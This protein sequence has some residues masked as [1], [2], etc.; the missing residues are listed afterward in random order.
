LAQALFGLKQA[1]S[2][3]F[4]LHCLNS[5]DDVY[6][7]INSMK[8]A[9]R[10]VVACIASL[11]FADV[12]AAPTA[13]VVTPPSKVAS[14]A[15]AT[16]TKG[17]PKVIRL[18]DAD[19]GAVA[20]GKAVFIPVANSCN[21][22]TP[23][24]EMNADGKGRFTITGA[25]GA[26]KLCYQA[27]GETD[28]VEQVPVS[29][30]IVLTLVQATT[31]EPDHVTQMEP[32]SITVNVKTDI[33]FPDAELGDHAY[34]VNAATG[35]CQSQVPTTMVG[36]KHN[37]FRITSTGTYTLCYRVPGAAE[38]VAQTSVSLKVIPQ[39]VLESMVNQWVRK[40]GT[41]DCNAL[42][43]ISHCGFFNKKGDCETKFF[44]D[45]SGK[46]YRCWWEYSTWPDRC[47][48]DME[49]LDPAKICK[50]GTCGGTPEMCWNPDDLE[51]PVRPFPNNPTS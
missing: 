3:P 46:G 34:F 8:T 23:T 5:S 47:K 49:T 37:S 44:V 48:G 11:A 50:A 40:H 18:S 28:I 27:E 43:Q 22:V 20:G 32:R 38:A 51:G 21:S 45:G 4:G 19:G 41:A 39:G 14:I 12:H 16:A 29:G 15:P 7:Y 10:L 2:R 30:T 42:T 33:R 25:A 13:N 35:S 36:M 17:R 31:V 1:R 24:T 26:Y 9:A 6:H